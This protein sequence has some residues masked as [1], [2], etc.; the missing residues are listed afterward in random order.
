MEYQPCRGRRTVYVSKKELQPILDLLSKK[1]PPGSEWRWGFNRAGKPRRGRI[2]AEEGI[3][4]DAI[5]AQA[6]AQKMA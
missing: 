4:L 5:V 6:R 3:D 2:S 1:H